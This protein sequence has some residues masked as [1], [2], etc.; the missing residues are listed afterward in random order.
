MGGYLALLFFLHIFASLFRKQHK[1][2]KD[3]WVAETTSL[4]N[5]RTRLGYRGFESPSFRKTKHEDVERHLFLFLCLWRKSIFGVGVKIKN[6]YEVVLVELFCKSPCGEQ[7][8]KALSEA[9]IGSVVANPPS[10]RRRTKGV[11]DSTPFVLYIKLNSRLHIWSR[12][13]CNYIN[14]CPTRLRLHSAE[15]GH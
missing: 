14:L 4:L 7:R 3:G 2:W 10:F 11:E 13:F 8:G 12:E 5:W 6:Y 9:T 15:L 1:V